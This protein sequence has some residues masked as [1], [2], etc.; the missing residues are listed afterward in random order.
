[1]DHA[2]RFKDDVKFMKS[3]PPFGECECFGE[4]GM[5]AVSRMLNMIHFSEYAS[6]FDQAGNRSILRLTRDATRV[7]VFLVSSAGYDNLNFLVRLYDGNDVA[8]LLNVANDVEMLRGHKARWMLDFPV[9]VK[10]EASVAAL[11]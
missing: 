5:Q 9:W 6:K 2:P 8:G 7:T 4:H 1:M 3:A 11:K 10:A